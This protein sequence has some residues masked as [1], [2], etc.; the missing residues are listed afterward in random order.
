VV[1]LSSESLSPCRLGFFA[2][3]FRPAFSSVERC[4]ARF[5]RK[6]HILLDHHEP[7]L[8]EPLMLEEVVLKIRSS[9]FGIADITRCSPNVRMELGMMVAL[10]KEVLL[11]QSHDDRSQQ[12]FDLRGFPLV[13]YDLKPGPMLL[14][15][16]PETG[17]PQPFEELLS[18][19]IDRLRA[20]RS[21]AATRPSV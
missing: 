18:G 13:R 14:A 9:H 19:F 12:P 20:A 4:I 21:A 11:L 17:E 15:L 10:R 16:S 3:P 7:L 6:K 2:R 1:A 5:L 8:G